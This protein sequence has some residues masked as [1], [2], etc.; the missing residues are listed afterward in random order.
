MCYM[1]VWYLEAVMMCV[2]RFAI[3]SIAILMG[4]ERKDDEMRWIGWCKSGEASG[5]VTCLTD[6]PYPF[7]PFHSSRMVE[8]VLLGSV[9]CM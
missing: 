1:D 9:L 6:H 5:R 3:F 2:M 7:E 8:V 4:R